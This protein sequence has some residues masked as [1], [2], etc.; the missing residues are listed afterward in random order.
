MRALLWRNPCGVGPGKL[1]V[2]VIVPITMLL[3]LDEQPGE[4]VGYGLIPAS[5]ARE[6]AAE[7]TWRLLLTDPLSGTLLDYGCTTYTPP[8]GLA[9]FVRAR[10]VYCRFPPCQQR[11]ATVDLDHTVPYESGVGS[12]SEHNLYALSAPHPTETAHGCPPATRTRVVLLPHTQ[13]RYPTHPIGD[14]APQTLGQR[15]KSF[16]PSDAPPDPLSRP[17]RHGRAVL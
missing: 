3:G 2:S 17:R 4:L 6:I 8:R 10:D 12:S 1:L 16:S 15:S 14:N 11:A 7:G 9:D 13:R 5:L